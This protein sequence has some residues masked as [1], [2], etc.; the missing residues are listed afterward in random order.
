MRDK[1]GRKGERGGR[2][3]GE[4]GLLRIVSYPIIPISQIGKYVLPKSSQVVRRLERSPPSPSPTLCLCYY[5]D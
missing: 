1:R 5:K 2:R 4:E 3:Q